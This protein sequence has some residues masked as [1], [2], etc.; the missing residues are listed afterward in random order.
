[1][2]PE[3]VVA[4]VTAELAPSAT[5]RDLV[6]ARTALEMARHALLMQTS[7]GWFF[8]DVA[9]VEATIVLR[10]A[11]R[12]LDL[13]RRLGR[14]WL[15][16]AFLER[17]RGAASNDPSQGTA[18]DVYRRAVQE[19]P[20]T[21][22]RIAATAV[23]LDRLGDAPM[24][25]GYDV[26][27]SDGSEDVVVVVEEASTGARDEVRVRATPRGAAP[28]CEVGGR[29]YRVAD[30]FLV[31]RAR[32]LDKVA[33]DAVRAVREARHDALGR[34][35]AVIDPL[36]G[37]QPTVPLDLAMLLG[38]EET[39]RVLA[40]MGEPGASLASLGA[41]VGALR[42]RGVTLAVPRLTGPL[43][44]RLTRALARLPDGVGEALDVLEFA[45]TTGVVLDLEHVRAMVARWW[46]RSG[47]AD[48]SGDLVRLRDRLGL[49]P[50]IGTARH[51]KSQ[52]DGV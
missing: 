4:A 27:L 5:S 35:R 29:R 24:L 14:S 28:V 51:E 17:L 7:C 10:Q 47:P 19:R 9:G 37:R 13:A 8:D 12:A 1:V 34:L 2:Q 15:E 30:L 23:V 20:V 43:G 33:D 25:P 52:P 41:E 6:Q 45:K 31:Q 48:P 36:I 50:E 39:D 32:L 42:A 11:G 16:A 40:Q 46:Q 21:P 38:F 22:A 3:R 49:S 26:A 44:E 18:A